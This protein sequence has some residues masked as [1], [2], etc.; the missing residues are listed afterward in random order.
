MASRII[1]AG[2]SSSAMIGIVGGIASAAGTPSSMASPSETAQVAATTPIPTPTVLVIQEIHRQVVIP[3]DSQPVAGPAPITGGAA[4][5]TPSSDVAVST[6]RPT[7]NGSV[8]AP[9]TGAPSA[10]ARGGGAS[11]V[12]TVKVPITGSSPA[13]VAVGG[14]APVTAPAPLASP[15]TTARPAPTTTAAPPAPRCSGSKCP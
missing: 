14:G 3:V 6:A 4:G 7:P 13:P 2:A 10:P 12:P 1:A 9:R 15:P 11:A 5:S 8:A